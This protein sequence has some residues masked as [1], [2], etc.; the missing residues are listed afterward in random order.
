MRDVIK[1][2][3]KKNKCMESKLSNG[4]LGVDKMVRTCSD[5]AS[6]DLLSMD[7]ILSLNKYM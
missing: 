7:A 4:K 5:L 6:K 2:P 1:S 3:S